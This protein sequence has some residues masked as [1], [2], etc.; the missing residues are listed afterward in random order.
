MWEEIKNAAKQVANATANQVEHRAF[1]NS[2]TTI[3]DTEQGLR[4]L[5]QK[6]DGMDDAEYESFC[7]TLVGMIGEAERALHN[8]E[9]SSPWGNSFEDRLAYGVAS[10]RSGESMKPDTSHQQMMVNGLNAIA[11]LSQQ[12]RQVRSAERGSSSNKPTLGSKTARIEEMLNNLD[13]GGG[14]DPAAMED[15]MSMTDEASIDRIAA[16]LKAREAK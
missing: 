7:G 2:L 10:F 1:I 9:N 16:K 12:F 8:A 5:K 3:D 11:L 4:V 6:I 13:K 15:L 14:I